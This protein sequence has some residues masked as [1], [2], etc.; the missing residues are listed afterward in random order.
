MLL[1]V[2]ALAL[3]LHAMRYNKSAHAPYLCFQVKRIRVTAPNPEAKAG[4]KAAGQKVASQK[5]A[6]L[7]AASLEAASL[8]AGSLEAA[9][10]EVILEASLEVILEVYPN[11][12]HTYIHQ[13]M[14]K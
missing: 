8:E 6:T 7:E 10:L 5:A 9:S 3:A 11:L 13:R 14:E 2:L 12:V 4:Q 1:A